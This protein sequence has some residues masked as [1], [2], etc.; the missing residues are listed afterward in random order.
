MGWGE[1]KPGAPRDPFFF[2]MYYCCCVCVSLSG[3]SLSLVGPRWQRALSLFLLVLTSFFGIRFGR[4]GCLS[5]VFLFV[6][7]ILA[8]GVEG[9][10]GLFN[11]VLVV[12]G[13]CLVQ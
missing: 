12:L 3:F 8:F 11:L 9:Q 7:L 10:M 4:S 6:F 13:G 1:K 5:P 2:L